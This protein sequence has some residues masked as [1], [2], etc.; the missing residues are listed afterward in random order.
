MCSQDTTEP[1]CPKKG[2]F[3]KICTLLLSAVLI[4]SATSGI[5]LKPPKLKPAHH[6]RV[7]LLLLPTPA[8]GSLGPALACSLSELLCSFGPITGCQEYESFLPLDSFPLYP[9]SKLVIF[10]KHKSGP[11]NLSISFRNPLA[12]SHH[13][14]EE[15]PSPPSLLRLSAAKHLPNP[16]GHVSLPG[17]NSPSGHAV[18]GPMRRDGSCI[19]NSHRLKCPNPA[20]LPGKS[21]NSPPRM[22]LLVIVGRGYDFTQHGCSVFLCAPFTVGNQLCNTNLCASLQA[23]ALTLKCC[24]HVCNPR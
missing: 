5:W 18:A 17:L 3:P 15:V 22:Q 16:P 14:Q 23:T 4:D 8:P 6:R 20:P 21:L 24:L 2:S 12:P 1:T 13:L 10:L 19:S 11:R 9:S 7:R